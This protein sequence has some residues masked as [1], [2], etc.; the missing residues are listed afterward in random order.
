MG[1]PLPVVDRLQQLAVPYNAF[2]EGNCFRKIKSVPTA[3]AARVTRQ[4]S[5]GLGSSQSIVSCEP[6]LRVWSEARTKGSLM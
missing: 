1:T 2:H 5:V 3:L 6:P 4:I